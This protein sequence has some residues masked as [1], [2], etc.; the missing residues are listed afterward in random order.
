[1]SFIESLT[2]TDWALLYISA[3]IV[4]FAKTGITG[5]GILAVPLFAMV[6]PAEKSAGLLLPVLCV[7]DL[8]AVFYYRNHADWKQIW[9]LMPWVA[10]GLLSATLIYYFGRQE[11][12]MM[13]DFIRTSMKPTMGIIVLLVQAFG[14]WRKNHKEVPK[15]KTSAGIAGVAAGFTSMLANA[16]G[17]IMAIYLLMMKLPKKT[18]IGTKAW[19][20]LIINYVKIPLMIVGAN[21]INQQTLILNAKLIPAILLGSFLGVRLVNIIPED[22]F[23][24]M[25]QILVFAS[26]LKLI[27]A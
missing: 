23:R 7:A 16:A 19:F 1:M 24:I 5:I 9:R 27:F 2:S 3:L 11:G 15:G 13:G 22:K 21:S 12:S 10:V 18:F 26:C 25:V 4:G 20:F 8:V 6:F 17:P 14:L